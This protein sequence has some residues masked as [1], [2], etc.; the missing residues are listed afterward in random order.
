MKRKT[1]KHLAFT[2]IGGL[3]LVVS[4]CSNDAGT[5]KAATNDTQTEQA[6]TTDGAAN[7]TAAN[8]TTTDA[9]APAEDRVMKDA[10]DH[11]VTIP[12]EP[13]AI[14]ASY[15][16][17]NLVA[18]GV[19]PVAQWMIKSDQVQAYLQ[20]SLSGVPG[21]PFDLPPEVVASYS[22]DLILIDGPDLVAGEK[23]KQYSAIAPTYVVGGAEN[24]DWRDELL[25]IGDVLGKKDEAQKVLDDYDAKAADAKTKVDEATGGAKKAAVLWVLEKDVFVVNQNLSSGDVIYNDLGM[26]VPDIVK[27]ASESSES[28]WSSLSL[29]LL[30]D[31]DADYLFLV[32]ASG[33]DK[34]Q[35]LS[36]PVWKNIP[37]VKEGQVYE[38]TG[39]SSWLYTGAIAN[40]KIIDDVLSSVAGGQ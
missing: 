32:N 19:K 21:I 11:E 15:L 33:K 35:V 16:E 8:E 27:Q 30:A 26:T 39:D 31:I 13:K 24:N 34:D 2:V 7:E 14:I 25:T 5:E 10:M 23:Y 36:D 4:A 6:A 37:A 18:L 28:N 12:A 22:P 3:A 9:A 29:E 38:F 40:G 20:D 1:F 17:D